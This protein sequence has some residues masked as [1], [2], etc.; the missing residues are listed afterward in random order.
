MLG[1]ISGGL[2]TGLDIITCLHSAIDVS[3]PEPIFLALVTLVA[4]SLATR[5]AV[6]PLA[7][8]LFAHPGTGVGVW[9]AATG[10]SVAFYRHFLCFRAPAFFSFGFLACRLLFPFS[11]PLLVCVSG[12]CAFLRFSLVLGY[13]NEFWRNGK[14]VNTGLFSESL[15]D[16]KTLE[17]I[18]LR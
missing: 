7:A 4:N 12:A 18:S 3:R 6:A 14:P 13:T 5:A 1:I 17:Y 2:G 15:T 8:F 11:R 10:W 9:W 16:N